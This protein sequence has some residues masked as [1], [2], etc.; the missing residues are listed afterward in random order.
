MGTFGGFGKDSKF[1]NR[2]KFVFKKSI[3]SRFSA[4]PWWQRIQILASPETNRK[5]KFIA[6]ILFFIIC[7]HGFNA[8][9][10]SLR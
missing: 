4:L 9:I 7:V 6:L 1:Q 10:A 5:M 2:L 8:E 3:T